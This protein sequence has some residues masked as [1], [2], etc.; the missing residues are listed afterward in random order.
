MK[1]CYILIITLLSIFNTAC[2]RPKICPKER[3]A[4]EDF[5]KSV[6]EYS[7]LYTFTSHF[8]ESWT[9]D[10]ERSPQWSSSYISCTEHAHDCYA[11]F[12]ENMSK[13]QID[14]IEQ[15]L[16]Y[17]LKTSYFNDSILKIDI[18]HIYNID[19]RFQAGFDTVSPPIYDFKEACFLLGTVKDSIMENGRYCYFDREI[20]P[21]DLMVYVIDAQPGIFWR[22]AE[23]AEKEPRA[24]ELPTLWKHGYS[25]GI[26]VSRSCG[27]VCWWA[28]AW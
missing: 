27:R 7:K 12:L 26:A 20:L 15:G 1:K 9:N 23:K 18:S 25:R 14:A 4:R 11:I 3:L 6:V 10:L 28:M 2:N 22:D 19:C 5:L 16:T 8:P 21:T 13:K 24:R 17:I